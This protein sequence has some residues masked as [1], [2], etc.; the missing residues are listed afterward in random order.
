MRLRLF[1]AALCCSSAGLVLLAAACRFSPQPVPRVVL[2][3]DRTSMPA[4]GASISHVSICSASGDSLPD[5][6][7][8]FTVRSGKYLAR[9]EQLRYAAPCWNA[10]VRAGVMPGTAV[11]GAGAATLNLTLQPDWADSEGDGTPD[12]LRLDSVDEARF[13]RWFTYLAEVQY[14]RK[15]E[16]LP[17]EIDDCAALIRFAY[18]ETL[19]AHDSEW[20]NHLKLPALPGIP[21]VRKYEYPHTPLGANLFV[22]EPGSYGQ[23]AD[24]KTL[25]RYN[26]HRVTGEIRRAKPGDILFFLQEGH[27]MPF[28]TMIYLGASQVDGSRGPYVLY[29]TGPDGMRKGEIRRLTVDELL[30]FPEPE[31]RPVPGNRSFLGCFHWNI[32]RKTE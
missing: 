26:A 6:A 15:P 24:A 32:F 3:A 14:F 13:R 20:A 17:A 1:A 11:L 22:T 25:R 4:D 31:W 21:A 9:V 19:R 28:H 7:I 23:F 8:D 2:K 16:E 5:T 18:R 10:T 27:R 30:R 12:F 29:H